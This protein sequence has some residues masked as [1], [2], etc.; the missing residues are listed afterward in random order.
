M[1]SSIIFSVIIILLLSPLAFC[2]DVNIGETY[3]IGATWWFLQQ[4]S[5][6]GKMLLRDPEGG[7]HFTWTFA[8]DDVASERYI[9]YSFMDDAEGDFDDQIADNTGRADDDERAGYSSIDYRLV[10]GSV[11]P[12]IVFHTFGRLALAYDWNR[13]VGA[14]TSIYFDS[15][16]R[17]IPLVG[18]GTIDRNGNA[19]V[20]SGTH[21]MGEDAVFPLVLWHAGNVGED[22]DVSEPTL[23]ERTT[24]LSHHIIASRESDQVALAWH[25][26]LAGVPAPEEWQNS[27]AY[28]MNNDLYLYESPDGEEWDFDNVTNITNTIPADHRREGL[29]AYGDTLRPF[30]DV[31]MIY[32]GDNV[33][34]VFSTRVLVPDPEEEEVPP[35]IRITEKKSFIWHWDSE[36]DSLTLVADGWYENDGD[37]GS[38]HN[39]V[40]RPSLGVDEDGVL[41]CIFRQVTEDDLNNGGLCMGEVMLSISSDEGETWSE[42]VN[43]TGTTNENGGNELIDENHPC[44]AELVDDNLHIS[45]LL[46]PEI[47]NEEPVMIYHRVPVEDLPDVDPLPMPREGFQ[48][49]NVEPVSV[50]QDVGLV[51]STIECN[52]YPNP[53]N[54][55]TN[56]TFSLNKPS[57]VSLFV[58]DLQGS[59]VAEKE[60]GKSTKGKH[61]MRINAE[62]WANGIY[63]ARL[64]AG[65]EQFSTKLVYMK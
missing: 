6:V 55:A 20:I 37:P 18:K 5:T 17:E 8:N 19:H 10:D 63:I 23:V 16:N 33:H 31:D 27:T 11:V 48:Y 50:E 43:L 14:F 34:V 30:N 36:S 51:P 1:K 56:L 57:E 49:H 29:L 32:L 26:N 12:S 13:G 60:L 38:M 45:Y 53:F 39:N 2:Q 9:F 22:D 41:Y 54:S 3:E 25:H 64:V 61:S 62:D 35:V 46:T 58:F 42:S 44:L 28:S 21:N 15:P 40:S 24:G 52:I 4:N 7:T 65:D 59:L 47:R